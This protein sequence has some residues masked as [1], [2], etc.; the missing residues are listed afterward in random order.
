LSNVDKV[1]HNNNRRQY[2]HTRRPK[3]N[4]N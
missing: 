2:R 3:L 4:V 1:L